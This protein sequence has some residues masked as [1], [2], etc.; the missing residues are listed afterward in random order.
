MCDENDNKDVIMAL[1]EWT[2]QITTLSTGTL[3]LSA[4]FI[5]NVLNGAAT[6]K[7]VLVSAWIAFAVSI[8]FGIFL[9]G[10]ACYLFSDKN[11]QKPDIYE[12]TTRVLA[13]I[14]FWTFLTGIIG[15]IVFVSINF[16]YS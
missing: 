2:K 14:H 9:M 12:M 4:A 16:L 11:R 5:K 6:H 15:F 7:W 10:N 13:Q 1:V 3:V 8:L